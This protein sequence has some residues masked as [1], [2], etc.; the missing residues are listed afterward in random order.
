MQASDV[1]KRDVVT[2]GQG[3]REVTGV[4]NRMVVVGKG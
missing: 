1:M 2:V 4:T 3:V